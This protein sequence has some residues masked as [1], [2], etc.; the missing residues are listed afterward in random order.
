MMLQKLKNNNKIIIN[1]DIDGILS[2]LILHHFCDCEI[3]GFS[4]SIDKIWIDQSKCKTIFDAVYIDM[5]VSDPNVVSID[6]HII[7]LNE[8]QHYYLSKNANKINPNIDNPRHHLPDKLYYTKYPFG[9]VH[10]I[11]SRLHKEGIN[12]NSLLLNQESDSLKFIDFLL[13]ADDAMKTSVESYVQNASEWWQWLKNYSDESPT[14]IAI[15]DYLKTID[16]SKSTEI[17][18]QIAIKLRKDF[19]CDTSD[20]GFKE[21][22]NH[23]QSIKENL[24]TYVQFLANLGGLKFPDLDLKLTCFSGRNYRI[25][26]KENQMDSFTKLNKIDGKTCFS[27]AFV[28]SSGRS[29]NFSYTI[30]NH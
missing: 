25:E 15:I 21:V 17:K 2:G 24:K 14:I 26:L 3:V 11:I 18:T 29:E 12:T 4:N 10:Y 23:D 30:M 8:E 7:A 16:A 22:C 13:R 20:G 19:H 5:F 6:Q 1:T 27:Y 28:R 9:T